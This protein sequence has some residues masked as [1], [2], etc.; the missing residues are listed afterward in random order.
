MKQRLTREEAVRMW[1]AVSALLAARKQE[2]AAGPRSWKELASVVGVT[3]PTLHEH[4]R[5]AREIDL[6]GS[7][8]SVAA[9]ASALSVSPR[10][11]L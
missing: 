8:P 4:R 10:D 11:L 3:P 7:W 2:L 1:A 5:Q 9:L 6:M